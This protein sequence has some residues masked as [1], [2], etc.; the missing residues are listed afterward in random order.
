V[1]G[2]FVATPSGFK[3]LTASAAR[4]AVGQLLTHAAQEGQGAEGTTPVVE[5]VA[6]A[7]GGPSTGFFE[8]AAGGH[9]AVLATWALAGFGLLVVADRLR[10]RAGSATPAVAGA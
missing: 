2:A 6:P 8:G 5:D 9:V 1:Y 7:A 4:G 3:F 10:E